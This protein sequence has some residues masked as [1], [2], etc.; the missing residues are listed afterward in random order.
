ME[1]E[2]SR[3]KKQ[4]KRNEKEIKGDLKLTNAALPIHYNVVLVSKGGEK[5]RIEIGSFFTSTSPW[6]SVFPHGLV[7][8]INEAVEVPISLKVI[9]HVLTLR[10]ADFQNRFITN[11][12]LDKEL[13]S[14]GENQNLE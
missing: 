12:H 14:L 8:G 13:A 9:T 4:V 2:T 3:K 1:N 7:I 5:N 11:E 10:G 6:H